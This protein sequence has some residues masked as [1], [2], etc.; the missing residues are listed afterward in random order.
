MSKIIVAD[1]DSLIALALVDLLDQGEA[2]VLPLRHLK[3]R[4]LSVF[5]K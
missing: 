5:W 4:L 2:L 3:L 1:T